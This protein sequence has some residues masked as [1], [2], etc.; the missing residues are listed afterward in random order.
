LIAKKQ[1]LLFSGNLSFINLKNKKISILD[2]LDEL[3]KKDV[4]IKV[5]CRVDLAGINNIKELLSLNFKYGKELVEIRHSEQP[6]RAIIYDEV[7]A[8]LKE[9]KEPTGKINELNQKVFIY[10]GFKDKE[11][12]IWMKRLFWKMFNESIDAN[13]RIEELNKII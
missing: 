8:T 9:V 13:K 2:T 7:L 11:W 1:L 5:L 10:Y 6:L 3:V 4:S 12:I